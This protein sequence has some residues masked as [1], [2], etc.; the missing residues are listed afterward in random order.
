[1]EQISCTREEKQLQR[2]LRKVQDCG[3]Y[4]EIEKETVDKNVVKKISILYDIFRR[5]NDEKNGKNKDFLYTSDIKDSLKYDDFVRVRFHIIPMERKNG[6]IKLEDEENYHYIENM[7]NIITNIYNPSSYDKFVNYKIE[8]DKEK[9]KCM[10]K[11]VNEI[12]CAYIYKYRSD[13]NIKLTFEV[14][15]HN[16]Y[17][18]LSYDYKKKLAIKNFKNKYTSLE[19]NDQFKFSIPQNIM[20]INS[21]GTVINTSNDPFE[22]DTLDR[23]NPFIF[24]SLEMIKE[25]HSTKNT[26]ILL[27]AKIDNDFFIKNTHYEEDMRRLIKLNRITNEY[28]RL[29]A[30]LSK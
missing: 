1:M 24:E 7:N 5:I 19:T 6:I 23:L 18:F 11:F 9:L 4:D 13:N 8:E 15:C 3:L 12:E 25:L 17:I 2:L 26:P 21:I 20:H 14:F 30:H 16:F 10:L 28:K 27:P 22:R 29:R